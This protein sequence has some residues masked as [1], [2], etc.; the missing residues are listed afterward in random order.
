M[1]NDFL[2][3]DYTSVHER[4]K[5]FREDYP[6][7][8]I[9]TKIVEWDDGLGVFRAEV[10]DEDDHVLGHGTG[11]ATRE[12][13]SFV[14]EKFYE[15][16]ETVAV[17]RAL[18]FAGY[19]IEHGIASQEEVES[20]QSGQSRTKPSQTQ[21]SEEEIDNMNFEHV[22]ARLNE[23]ADLEWYDDES[24]DAQA[25]LFARFWE[26]NIEGSKQ[27]RYRFLSELLDR[28]VESTTDLSKGE[29]GVLIDLTQNNPTAFVE[30]ANKFAADGTEDMFE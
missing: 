21:S 15:K 3:D 11:H 28:K 23:K 29:L 1:S 13:D 19:G 25:Q 2:P 5:E 26:D 4:I 30:F 16:G 6:K 20:V 7:G 24:S 12:A 10:L 14:G 17:G 8:Q 18:A 9:L 27:D 22:R